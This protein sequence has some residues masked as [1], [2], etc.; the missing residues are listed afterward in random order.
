MAPILEGAR[1]MKT[2]VV[3]SLFLSSGLLHGCLAEEDLADDELLADEQYLCSTMATD[4]LQVPFGFG[5]HT[6]TENASETSTCPY[7]VAISMQGPTGVQ[8]SPD[9]IHFDMHLAPSFQV[10]QGYCTSLR[11]AGSLKVG[12]PNSTFTLSQV[13]GVPG[14]W[15]NGACK[16]GMTYTT[17]IGASTWLRFEGRAM[18]TLSRVIPPLEVTV[19]ED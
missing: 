11:F 1:D 16:V 12:Y 2:S 13:H 8:P 18:S 7:I 9:A 19:T 3:L 14:V 10:S 6:V 17:F 5:S 4:T 15:Q